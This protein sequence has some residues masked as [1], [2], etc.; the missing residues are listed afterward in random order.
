MLNIKKILTSIFWQN[1]LYTLYT[2]KELRKY[3]HCCILARKISNEASA[4]SFWGRICEIFQIPDKFY[5]PPLQSLRAAMK[6]QASRCWLERRIFITLNMYSIVY[7]GTRI[8]GS[9]SRNMELG[10]S[11]CVHTRAADET[12]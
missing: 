5:G 11:S 6:D 4:R 10:W 3:F 2:N 12:Y 7:I 9:I 1:R 8:P